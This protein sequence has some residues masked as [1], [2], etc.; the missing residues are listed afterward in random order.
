[1]CTVLLGFG[2]LNLPL[3][4]PNQSL[5]GWFSRKILRL[6][7]LIA[8]HHAPDF[9]SDS[10]M[11]LNC[12]LFGFDFIT[13]QS[14]FRERRLEIK[15]GEFKT[16]HIIKKVLRRWNILACLY[17]GESHLVET[18][19]TSMLEQW[20]PHYTSLLG[21]TGKPSVVFHQAQSQVQALFFLGVQFVT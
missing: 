11:R 17:V 19:V 6:Y 14:M 7:A 21:G 9:V 16:P 18:K 2:I 8:Q 5:N 12:A 3:M 4:F 15:S 10:A 13:V 1:M 20:M